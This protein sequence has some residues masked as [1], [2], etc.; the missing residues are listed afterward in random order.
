MPILYMHV[1]TSSVAKRHWAELTRIW[2]GTSVQV[3]VGGQYVTPGKDGR[4]AS[5]WTA[6]AALL[7]DG[8]LPF[9]VCFYLTSGLVR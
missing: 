9:F 6:E 3:Q 2:F 8:S 7:V 5:V 4:A 1:Q